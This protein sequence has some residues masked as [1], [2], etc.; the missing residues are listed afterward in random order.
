MFL[1]FTQTCRSDFL[2]HASLHA[3]ERVLAK[4]P[5][6]SQGS[7]NSLPPAFFFF[8]FFCFSAST[9]LSSRR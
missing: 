6:P 7:E 8:S 4:Q 2:H 5:V 3:V 1:P 9:I